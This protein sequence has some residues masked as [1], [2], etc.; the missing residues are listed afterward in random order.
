ML[1]I[2]L[3]ILS[4]QISCQLTI[5]NLY[6]NQASDEWT[7]LSYTWGDDPPEKEILLNGKSFRVR[8]N[9]WDFLEIITRSRLWTGSMHKL[10]KY[11]S[12]Q[13]MSRRAWSKIRLRLSQN[14]TP[15]EG[16]SS[17]YQ[18]TWRERGR[19]AMQHI[20]V[21]HGSY[22]NSFWPRRSLYGMD[23]PRWRREHSP[24]CSDGLVVSKWGCEIPQ[25]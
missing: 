12:R 11:S 10:L 14:G 21:A 17:Y 6:Q 18:N 2:T 23:N 24:G 20:G 4:D 7:A 9:L 15:D 1:S 22:K 19:S 16:N 13:V 5:A 3:A 8:K 25:P